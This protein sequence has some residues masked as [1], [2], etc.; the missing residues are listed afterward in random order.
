MLLFVLFLIYLYIIFIL[1]L[2]FVLIKMKDII[3][4]NL[5]Y[6]YLNFPYPNL[7]VF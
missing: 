7:V 6:F 1:F 3:F 5:N 2:F 4:Y